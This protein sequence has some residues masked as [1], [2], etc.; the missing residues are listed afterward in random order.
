MLETIVALKSYGVGVN[1]KNIGSIQVPNI[2]STDWLNSDSTWF[3]SA[4]VVPA[5]FLW[6]IELICR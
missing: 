2:I 3:I 1:W 6:V 5:L 4:L